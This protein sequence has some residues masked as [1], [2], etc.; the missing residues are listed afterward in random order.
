MSGIKK[1]ETE[2][3]VLRRFTGEDLEDLHEIL[4]DSLTMKDVEP[5]YNIKKTE[6]FLNKFCVED[7]GALAAVLKGP[8]KVIGYLLF[9][10]IEPGVFEMGW[11]FNRAYW[12]MGFAYEA[13]SELVRYAFE[14]LKAHRVFSEAID[15]IRSV[16]LMKKLGMQLEGVQR[17]HTRNNAGEWSDLYLCGMLDSDYRSLQENNK[18]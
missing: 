9:N 12:R 14:K 18:E 1:I 10:E 13:C 6:R 17:G 4:S 5:P 15:S 3:L 8:D 2:R 16:G 7:G 11:I